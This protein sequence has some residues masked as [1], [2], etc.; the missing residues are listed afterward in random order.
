MTPW[1]FSACVRLS[2]WSF[3]PVPLTNSDPVVELPPVFG[4]RFTTSPPLFALAQP[5]RGGEGDLFGRAGV[6]HIARRR[7]A[8]CTCDRDTVERETP[9]VAPASMD[10]KLRGRRAGH[11]V[12]RGG[13]HPGDEHD[14]R[15]V[16]ANGRKCLHDVAG[17]VV[18]AAA[19]RTS[20]MGS[21]AVTVIVSSS[22]PGSSRALTLAVN[23]LVISTRFPH[24]WTEAFSLRM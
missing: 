13:D 22:A 12:V 8:G 10:G 20:T 14:E 3:S 6:D 16:T 11:D 24:V 7:V 21:S 19:L 18:A 15:V 23:A 1:F 4:T 5:S 9:L 2:D 17:S